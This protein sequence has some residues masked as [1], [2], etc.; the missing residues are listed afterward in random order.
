MMKHLFLLLASLSLFTACG[1]D[2]RSDMGDADLPEWFLNQPPLCGVGVQKVRGNVGSAKKFAQANARDD[3]SRQLE[4]KVKSM[5]EQYNQEGGNQDGEISE[6]L[7]TSASVSL[8][9]QTINGSVPKKTALKEGQ[10]YSLVCLEPGALENAIDKMKSL[11]E[12][13]RR[14]LKRRADAAHKRRE[15]MMKSYDDQ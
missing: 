3:L 11:G 9:K 15:E 10:L 8:S 14:A 6:E 4:T 7:A 13:Q 12:A 2:K 1:G 5:I